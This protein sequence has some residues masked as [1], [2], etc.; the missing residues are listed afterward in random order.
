M[1]ERDLAVRAGKRRDGGSGA[2]ND[3]CDREHDQRPGEEAPGTTLDQRRRPVALT[4]GGARLGENL[5]DQ[6]RLFGTTM[7]AAQLARFPATS[8]PLYVSV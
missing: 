1:D 8:A 4:G 5:A 6:R 7:R 2:G 3:A